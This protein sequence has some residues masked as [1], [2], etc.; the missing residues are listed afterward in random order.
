MLFHS[1]LLVCCSLAE[2]IPL[3]SVSRLSPAVIG[4]SE[5]VV[6][7]STDGM[8]RDTLLIGPKS[9]TMMS[10]TLGPAKV[11]VLERSNPVAEHKIPD[12]LP[13]PVSLSN[14]WLFF[15]TRTAT[16][17]A[18]RAL[19]IRTG[20]TVT[21]WEDFMPFA[22]A[23]QEDRIAVVGL[24]SGARQ[25]LRLAS[26]PGLE[27]R[28]VL[29]LPGGLLMGPLLQILSFSGPDSLS[30]I[31]IWE[32][33][34]VTLSTTA[35]SVRAADKVFF[36]GSSIDASR[37]WPGGKPNSRR[38]VVLAHFP[39]GNGRSTLL[40][41]PYRGEDGYRAAE[42]E[43]NGSEIRS[44]NMATSPAPITGSASFRPT[45]AAAANGGLFVV[46]PDGLQRSYRRP[47]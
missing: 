14:S 43:A 27:Q 6:A 32:A 45:T 41:G 28:S 20:K 16:N 8:G 12:L 23:I 35:D 30:L 19:E 46:S 39:L 40:L 38:V 1:V 2:S 13:H 47:Q 17:V 37:S 29:A 34:S 31:N 10:P 4:S 5:S 21:L 25:E 26:G 3:D 33:S 7:Y 36:R 11:V 9:G 42:F 24:G 44:Y 22:V 18:S 15:A